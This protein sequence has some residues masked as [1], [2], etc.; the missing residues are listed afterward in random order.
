MVLVTGQISLVVFFLITLAW[1]QVHRNQW[2]KAG[3]ALGIAMSIKL[4]LLILV[5]YLLLRRK[6]VCL[7]ISLSIFLLSFLIGLMVFGVQAH[8]DWF[9]ILK[10][11]DWEWAGMNASIVGLFK[12]IFSETPQFYPILLIPN[13]INPL[14]IISSSIVLII[15]FMT[16]YLK[17]YNNSTDMDFSLLLISSLLISP[18][19]WQYFFWLTVGPLFGLIVYWSS[20]TKLSPF[21]FSNYIFP[22]LFFVFSIPGLFFPFSAILL[23]EPNPL[24]TITIGSIYFWTDLFLW[25]GCI[26][27]YFLMNKSPVLRQ[28]RKL[29]VCRPPKRA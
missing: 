5:P 26:Y 27:Y 23:F 20:D 18:L 14:Y 19:G 13:L 21:N 1:S 12:R 8:R 10:S 3:L 16:I 7:S 6:I 28:S 2:I 4:Q 15:T 11:I 25:I 24:A 17:R 9:T 22:K 29:D